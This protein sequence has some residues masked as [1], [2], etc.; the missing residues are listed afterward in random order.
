MI[1]DVEPPE[2]ELE[3][4]SLFLK[5]QTLGFKYAEATDR[6]GFTL[7]TMFMDKVTELHPESPKKA[8]DYLT[9]VAVCLVHKKGLG[10]PEKTTFPADFSI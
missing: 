5:A 2:D 1:T 7:A 3:Y 8:Y 6:D 4:C 10:E 9:N